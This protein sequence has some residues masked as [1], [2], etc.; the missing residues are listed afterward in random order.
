MNLIK[1]K[2]GQI[3]TKDVVDQQ[4]RK[5]ALTQLVKEGTL[6]RIKR[7]VYMLTEEAEVG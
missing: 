3:E 7:G 2:N 5:G 1:R 4:L 6:I